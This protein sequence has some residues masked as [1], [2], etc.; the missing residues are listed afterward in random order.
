MHNNDNFTGIQPG[1]TTATPL[2][3]TLRG[4]AISKNEALTGSKQAPSV[5]H[6]FF[7]IR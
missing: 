3:Q 7:Q 5:F 2:R 1:A 4:E 6:P